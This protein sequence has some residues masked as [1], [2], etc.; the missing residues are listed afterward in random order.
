M[1]GTGKPPVRLPAVGRARPP[2]PGLSSTGPRRPTG[3]APP[4]PRSVSENQQVRPASSMVDLRVTAAVNS[5]SEHNVRVP[6]RPPPVPGSSRR[7]GSPLSMS[8]GPIAPPLPP[9]NALSSLRKTSA[10][11]TAPPPPPPPTNRNAPSPPL[12]TRNPRAQTPPSSRNVL[13][14]P[15][16]PPPPPAPQTNGQYPRLPT[17]P[18]PPPSLSPPRRTSP[19]LLAPPLPPPPTLPSASPPGRS[20]F[21]NGPTQNPPGVAPLPQFQAPARLGAS[22]LP[23]VPPGWTSPVH[24]TPSPPAPATLSLKPVITKSITY[25]LWGRG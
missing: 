18:P 23:S 4:I 11:S 22:N 1:L 13:T 14:P 6:G 20:L 2:P 10:P 7:P 16:A 9:P 19:S 15:P 17:A 25:R 5:A 3:A 21:A 12:S 24:T 8:S